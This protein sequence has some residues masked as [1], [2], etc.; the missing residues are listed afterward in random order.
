M[1]FTNRVQVLG[2]KASKGVIEE[3]G[4]AY[5]STKVYV[6]ADLDIRSGNAKGQACTEYSLGVAEDF[7]KFKHLSF[8]FDADAEFEIVT[9]GKASKTL[10]LAVMPVAKQT[11]QPPPKV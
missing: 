8:P 10:L 7:Q 5:D 4:Q 9:S 6:L 3:S 2:M 1:K 11:V